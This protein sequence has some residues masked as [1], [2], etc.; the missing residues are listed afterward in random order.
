[1][2]PYNEGPEGPIY[3]TPIVGMVG[4]LPDP[5]RAAPSAFARP[6]AGAEPD[7]VALVGPFR[8]SAAASELEKLRGELS[9]ELPPFDL[10]AVVEAFALVREAVRAGELASAH[11]V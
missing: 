3:P 7:L 1:V 2:S 5:G 10:A 8:P 9:A 4:E 6:A 11:D